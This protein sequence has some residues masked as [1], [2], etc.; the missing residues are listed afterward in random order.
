MALLYNK[1]KDFILYLTQKSRFSIRYPVKVA[2]H[3]NAL[4]RLFPEDVM[5]KENVEDDDLPRHYFA[6]RRYGNINAFYDD[7]L[8]QRA[9][10]KFNFLLKVDIKHCFDEICPEALHK[11]VY[12]RQE[13]KPG[14]G[15]VADFIRLQNEIL[16]REGNVSEAMKPEDGIAIGPE[17]SRIYAEIV[18]QSVDIQLKKKLERK[19]LKNEVD[20][21]FYRYVDDG[22]FF[23]NDLKVM[24]QFHS[25]YN[26]V[27]KGWELEIN[28]KKLEK[29]YTKPFMSSL[30]IAKIKLCDLVDEMFIFRPETVEG[31]IRLE[32]GKYKDPP[33]YISSKETIRKFQSIVKEQ[34]L[35]CGQVTACLLAKI[36]RNMRDLAMSKFGKIYHVYVEK[37]LT[38]D[39]DPVGEEIK[40]SYEWSFIDFCCELVS[41]LFY[42][43]ACDPRM[44][45]SI[46]VVQLVM[47]ILGY[48]DGGLA[49]AEKLEK[50]GEKAV[51]FQPEVRYKL[52][53][54]VNDELC[55]ALSANRER[56]LES[57]NLLMIYH[58]M[59]KHFRPTA[60][61]LKTLIGDKDDKFSDRFDFLSI[62]T[63]EHLVGKHYRNS[64]LQNIIISWIKEQ[65]GIR[66]EL[67]PTESVYLLLLTLSCPYFDDNTKKNVCQ[68]YGIDKA[69]SEELVTHADQYE[70]LFIDWRS[71]KLLTMANRKKNLQVY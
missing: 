26:A 43:F 57:V 50:Y 13:E 68:L 59:P 71:R 31:L 10:K 30:A 52:Y 40:R 51:R 60:N 28:Y 23:C 4:K 9:E 21:A 17:F 64:Q 70:N 36:S 63:L 8:Y 7:Y 16:P 55:L 56:P 22:F 48:V 15:F 38:G 29:Y 54:R 33:F 24:K 44:S 69:I 37:Q 32:K 49:K 2:S 47:E 46:R 1:Y 67:S 12:G 42:V 62:F 27:L 6:Y 58:Q 61:K 39:I 41:F 5:N 34:K 11:A 65:A 35:N 45:T 20:Y 19:E 53:R 25:I 66:K 18:L 14:I 3:Q